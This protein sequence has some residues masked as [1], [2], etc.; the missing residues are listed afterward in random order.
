MNVLLTGG[1]GYIGTHTAV[2]L[3]EAGYDVVIA[4]NLSNSSPDAVARV[5]SIT[6][7]Q[8]PSYCIDVADRDDLSEIFSRH[9]IGAVIHLAG[10][11]AVGESV[12]KP[13]MYYRNNID[14]TL[15]LLEV[16][17]KYGVNNIIFSS[18]ATVYGIPERI[19]LD[20]GCRVGQCAN[21]YG[22][23]K[24]MIE[25]IITDAANADSNMSAVLLRYFN[26]VGAHRSGKIGENPK[27]IPNNLMP[28]LI[29][30]ASGRS[31]GLTVFGDD[32]NTPDGTG[33]R[34]YIHVT[35]LARGHVMAIS[36]AEEHKGVEVF[37][38]G[39]GKGYSVYDM[40]H[41]FERVNHVKVPYRVCGRR[42]GDIDEYYANPEK[43]ERVLGWKAQLTLEDMCRDSWNWAKNK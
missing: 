9:E 6:G 43:A 33:V 16:M 22:R 26:P 19:P 5:T 2:E 37:N 29:E 41:T 23:T 8:I 20:E 28:R 21:P 14:T 10:L 18:S 36:Y 39:T 25:E 13:L 40:I 1:A 11:K 12:E 38:L 27:G 34:D 35:D 3:I 17:A 4:D 24:M 42:F 30:A 7:K 32:Y 31:D 15:S